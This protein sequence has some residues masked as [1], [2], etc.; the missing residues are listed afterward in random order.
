MRV[1]TGNGMAQIG[2][3]T[4]GRESSSQPTGT[5]TIDVSNLRDPLSS[6]S[7]RATYTDGRAGEVQKFVSDDPRIPAI[8]DMVILLADMYVKPPSGGTSKWVSFVFKDVHGKWIAPAV[9]ELIADS[10]S[11]LGYQVAVAHWEIK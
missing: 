9:G 11:N 2:I 1:P 5:Y 10:L 4:A 6:K 3:Y 8:R 7:L